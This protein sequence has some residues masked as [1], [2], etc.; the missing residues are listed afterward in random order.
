MFPQLCE[1]VG[2]DC[3]TCTA[4]AA[5]ELARACTGLQTTRVRQL[6]AQIYP[7]PACARMHAHFTASYQASQFEQ[8]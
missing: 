2:L 7:D 6:F 8:A 5:R 4:G 3:Q 1:E